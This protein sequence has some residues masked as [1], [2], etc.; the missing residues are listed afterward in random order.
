VAAYLLGRC[1][2]R[3]SSPEFDV[4]SEELEDSPL[5]KHCTEVSAGALLL[6]NKFGETIFMAAPKLARGEE[7]GIMVC[8][9]FG[10]G[11]WKR[12][13]EGSTM[14]SPT[15]ACIN[16]RVPSPETFKFIN[17]ELELC[18]LNPGDE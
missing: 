9:K 8:G 10:L 13:E 3:I 5:E 17:D 18:R 11:V 2:R 1:L 4:P 15:E 7:T 12:A 6:N 16:L 14:G